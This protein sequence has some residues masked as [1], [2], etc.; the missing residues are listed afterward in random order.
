[1]VELYELLPLQHFGN[2]SYYYY[3]YIFLEK[4]KTKIDVNGLTYKD[5]KLIDGALFDGQSSK[6][7]KLKIFNSTYYFDSQTLTK[8][9]LPYANIENGILLVVVLSLS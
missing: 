3:Y 6:S 5:V 1:M 8:K 7:V 2:S 4:I 9:L